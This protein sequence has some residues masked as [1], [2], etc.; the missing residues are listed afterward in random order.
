MRLWSIHPAYLD[1]KGLV[2]L[3]REGLLAQKVLLG[4]TAG[5]RNHPQ[6]KRFK[7]AGNPQ[8]A[9]ASYLRAVQQEA[10]RRGYHFDKSKIIHRRITKKI[11]V[12]NGQV[13]Y[14][15]THL[16][17]KLEKRSPELFLK[18]KQ[19]KKITLH[20]LFELTEGEVEAW[21]VVTPKENKRHSK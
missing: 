11:K 2:A 20:P 9:I 8:G 16:L 10:E 21:E 4:K 15:Y 17:A 6:L 13:D 18:I 7:E 1:S 12:T 19:Q 3:W 14:E 5:Y